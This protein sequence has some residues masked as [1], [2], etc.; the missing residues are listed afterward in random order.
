[1]SAY[2]KLNLLPIKSISLVSSS[3][4]RQRRLT[5]TKVY[6]KLPCSVRKEL[7]HKPLKVTAAKRSFP[8]MYIIDKTCFD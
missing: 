7:S 2:E 4:E 3:R 8:S 1:M 6:Y 5:Q